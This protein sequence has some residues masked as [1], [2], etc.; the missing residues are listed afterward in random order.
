MLGIK[1]IPRER[2]NKSSF[3]NNTII[4]EIKEAMKNWKTPITEEATPALEGKYSKILAVLFP[5]IKPFIP[6][7]KAINKEA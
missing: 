4:K 1:N 2:I 6:T 7:Y 5:K 3:E